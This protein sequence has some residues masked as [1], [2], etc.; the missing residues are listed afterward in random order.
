MADYYETLEVPKA[1]T[2]EEIKKAYRKQALKYHPD[3]NPGD[4][5][6]EKQFKEI[7]EAYEVLSDDKKRQIYDR[8]GKEALSGFGGA[9]GGAHY[10]SMEEA[11]RTFMGAFGGMGAT[12]FLKTSLEG[13]ER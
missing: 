3:R 7:A 2:A 4:A 6:A 12:P 8:H 1:A 13:V 11:L 10:E 5:A 9:G